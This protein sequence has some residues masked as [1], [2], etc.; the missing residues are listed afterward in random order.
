[1]KC[2]NAVDL[3]VD[4]LMDS[5]DDEQRKELSAHIQSC[6]SCAAEA[7]K[8]TATWKELGELTVPRP[9][10]Q[11][12]FEFGRRLTAQRSRHRYAP[13]L[14]LAASIALVLLGAAGGSFLARSGEAP[15]GAPPG[16][17]TTFPLPVRGDQP[18]DQVPGERLV[19]EYRDWALSLAGEGRLAGANKLTDE[20]GRWLSGSAAGDDRTRSDIQGYFLVNASSYSEALRIAEA[21]PHIRYGGTFEIR[22]IDPT[23]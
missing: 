6:E 5:L 20:P 4:S 8:M 22:Q 1:M 2:E 13:L 16:G 10:P 23:D 11:A 14:R 15:P 18:D 21:S 19:Q 3:I 9:A 17:G 7:E 12:A